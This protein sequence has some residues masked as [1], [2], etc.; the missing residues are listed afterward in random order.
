MESI[1]VGTP[2]ICSN[3]TSLPD[4]ILTKDLTFDP[5]DTKS[6]ARLMIEL[7][8]KGKTYHAF[9]DNHD[10]MKSKLLNVRTAESLRNVYKQ[11][12]TKKDL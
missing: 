11:M 4:T 1:L 3:V 10:L 7:I 9:K 5:D 6:M 2:A 12:I 8:E